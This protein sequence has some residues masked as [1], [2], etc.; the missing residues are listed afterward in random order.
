MGILVLWLHE[1]MHLL[2][3]NPD[4]F[5]LKLQST[6]Q[7]LSALTP[8][9]RIMKNAKSMTTEPWRTMGLIS[10]VPYN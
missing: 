10:S 1:F 2:F 4:V 9:L 7:I 5:H 8:R 6:C 3:S